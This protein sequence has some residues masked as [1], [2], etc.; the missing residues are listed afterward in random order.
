M[1]KVSLSICRNWPV[2]TW[3]H[4][5]SRANCQLPNSSSIPPL[6]LALS[7][8]YSSVLYALWSR[9]L[10]SQ[11]QALSVSCLCPYFSGSHKLSGCL[12]I[13][14]L[15]SCTLRGPLTAPPL[16]VFRIQTAAMLELLAMLMDPFVSHW[17]TWKD[18]RYILML[19]WLCTFHWW[20]NGFTW[21]FISNNVH[22]C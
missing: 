2:G 12:S 8:S 13:V 4:L 22:T 16:S 18:E 21:T 15:G 10:Y 7:T 6:S 14:E 17:N 9:G 1:C 3:E 11:I 20:I 5:T 19:F